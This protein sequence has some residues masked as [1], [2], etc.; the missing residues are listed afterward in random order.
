MTMTRPAHIIALAVILSTAACSPGVDE[1]TTGDG[2]WQLR[3]ETDKFTDQTNR[4]AQRTFVQDDAQITLEVSCNN[5]G[6]TYQAT[7]FD[8]DGKG[9][10]FSTQSGFDYYG[11]PY[12]NTR[13]WMRFDDLGTIP[14][15]ASIPHYSNQADILVRWEKQDAVQARNVLL[16][17]QFVDRSTDLEFD[18]SDSAVQRVLEPCAEAMEQQAQSP[19]AANEQIRN[20]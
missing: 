14:F 1:E 20:R 4:S 18:Q 19:Q 17:L 16:R 7:A 13:V 8:A 12:T 2:G 9:L 15:S 3:E 6:V 11:N 10:D 5:G